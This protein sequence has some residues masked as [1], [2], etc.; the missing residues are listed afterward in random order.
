[1]IP[2]VGASVEYAL[3]AR[4]GLNQKQDV[5]VRIIITIKLHYDMMH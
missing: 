3:A 2:P 4:K 5:V 1:M